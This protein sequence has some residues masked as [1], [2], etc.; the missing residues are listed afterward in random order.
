MTITDWMVVIAIWVLVPLWV[1][2]KYRHSRKLG[3][4]HHDKSCQF[5]GRVIG[6]R[7]DCPLR[8]YQDDKEN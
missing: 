2:F 4:Y 6:H 7:W 1:W 5:C 3:K 8:K